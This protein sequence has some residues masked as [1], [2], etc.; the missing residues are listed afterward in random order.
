MKTSEKSFFT[1]ADE[2][3]VFL[4]SVKLYSHGVSLVRDSGSRYNNS[5]HERSAEQVIH[6]KFF[7]HKP[8]GEIQGFSRH[9][10][11]RLRRALV[12]MSS[13]FKC[14]CVGIT[15]TLPFKGDFHNECEY[16][17]L[18][19][20]YK[21]AFNRFGVSM[22][23]RFGSSCGIFRHELQRRRVP[24]CHIVFFL[25]DLDFK[26]VHSGRNSNIAELRA[27]VYSYWLSALQ[28]FT[29]D[30]N[31]NGFVKHGVKVD[32]IDTRDNIA[33]FRYLC[34]HASKH[35]RD[36][37]GYLGKQWGFMN[38]ALFVSA[39]SVEV[40]FRTDRQKTVFVR[41]VR[42]CCRYTVSAKCVFKH[43]L[44]RLGQLKGCYFVGVSTT[45]K[46]VKA[47]RDSVIC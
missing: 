40:S 36:Q 39:P 33:V 34:D 17:I 21:K 20:A 2:H 30:V 14:S 45:K 18:A 11:L 5:R 24:H 4:K 9:A 27:I 3:A 22:R 19:K 35:K 41:H 46:I 25:S 15:L 23:R 12:S 6:D 38:R 10:S 37:L 26:L 16:K 29:F 7:N 32:R 8:R 1:S 31:L 13:S 47:V 43:K 44:T 42:K 28:G